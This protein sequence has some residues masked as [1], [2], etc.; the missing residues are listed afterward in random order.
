MGS[1]FKSFGLVFV[2]VLAGV[3]LS[4]NFSAV[5]QRDAAKY[6]LPIDEL[7][8]FAEVFGAIKSGYVESVEDKKLITEA[9]NGMLTGLD[10]HSAYLDQEAFKE[11][12]VGTQGEFGGLGIEVGMEDGFVK[13]VSPIEDTPAFRAGLKP[14]DLIIK[15]DDTPVKGMSLNDAVK[16][17]RGKPK[18]AIRSRSC[19][20]A[21]RSR[22]RSRWCAT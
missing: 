10:P 17:M 13:V 16:R 21:R 7:R 4:L 6:P 3:L 1:R 8:S 18:T 22:S 19:A 14:G 15:L 5:A 2:G 9:I 12:Q 20:R 11:L